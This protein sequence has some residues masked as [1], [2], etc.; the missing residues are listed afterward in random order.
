[1]ADLKSGVRL[2]S[3]VCSTEVMIVHSDNPQTEILCGGAVMVQLGEV[4]NSG[5]T[6]SSDHSIGT[7]LGKRYEDA[8]KTIEVLCLKAGEGSLS[9]GDTPLVVKEAKKLPSSD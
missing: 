9:I 7:L 2:K 8:G 3:S 4:A 6:L 1:M 5:E